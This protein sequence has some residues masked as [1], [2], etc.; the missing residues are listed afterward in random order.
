[1]RATSSSVSV[2][3]VSARS[4]AHSS[5]E[6]TRYGDSGLAARTSNCPLPSATTRRFFRQARL[7]RAGLQFRHHVR[8]RDALRAQDDEQ[9][10]QHVGRVPREP[11]TV[12]LDRREGSLDARLAELFRALLH[13]GVKKLARI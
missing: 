1:R 2:S 5:R 8:E 12:V 13:T 3:G 4:D 7:G 6:N 11:P 10:T 9:V